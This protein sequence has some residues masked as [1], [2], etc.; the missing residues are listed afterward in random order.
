MRSEMREEHN[1]VATYN[2]EEVRQRLARVMERVRDHALDEL[3][4]QSIET[5]SAVAFESPA[6][7]IY[8]IDRA[9]EEVLLP[10][11]E[12]ELQP[13]L[14]FALIC[15]GVNDEQPLAFPRSTPLE[16]CEARVI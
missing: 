5:L 7:Q 16:E 15:E 6:D 1:L 13:A 10:A 12:E 4:R 9:V 11:L 14:S 2:H 3:R 8:V